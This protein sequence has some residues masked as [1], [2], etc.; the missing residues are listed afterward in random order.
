MTGIYLSCFLS[1][2]CVAWIVRQGSRQPRLKP[3]AGD[4][5]WE[6]RLLEYQDSVGRSCM[7]WSWVLQRPS[8]RINVI[9]L[10]QTGRLGRLY[11][12]LRN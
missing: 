6:L 8:G 2:V 10:S 1:V 3:D 12:L 4:W 9:P 11:R 5:R 7:R